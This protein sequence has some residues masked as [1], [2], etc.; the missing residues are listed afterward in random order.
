[1][2]VFFDGLVLMESCSSSSKPA[3]VVGGAPTGRAPASRGASSWA[4]IGWIAEGRAGSAVLLLPRSASSPSYPPARG[5]AGPRLPRGFVL[6][7]LPG[8]IR[9]PQ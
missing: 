4:L 5:L 7:A 2:A 3:A 6:V 9:N 1:M 8:T